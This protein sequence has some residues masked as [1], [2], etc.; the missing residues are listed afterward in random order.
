MRLI[1]TT[2]LELCQFFDSNVPEYAI[3]SHCWSDDEVTFQEFE[4]R[5]NR[6]GCG[7]QKITD[8]CGLA[9]KRNIEWA[10]IDTICIDKTSSTELSEAINSMFRW[11]E[12]AAICFAFLSDTEMRQNGA[13]L[14]ACR[15]F[16]RGWT[17]QELLAPPKV[18][19]LDGSLHHIG[20]RRSLA[21]N[22]AAVTGIEERYLLEPQSFREACIAQRMSWAAG[23][24]TSR[25]EDVAYSL[26]GL[27]NVNMPLLY[28]EGGH[29]AFLR[30]QQHIISQS[31][32]E[33]IFAWTSKIP[34]ERRGMISKWP[35]EFGACGDV[36]CSNSLMKRPPYTLTSQ[37]LEFS[38]AAAFAPDW[39]TPFLPRNFGPPMVQLDCEVRSASAPAKSVSIRL[40]RALDGDQIWHRADASKLDLRPQSRL[41]HTLDV[42][43]HGYTKVYIPQLESE[44]GRY[45][46]LKPERR[47]LSDM[48]I[49]NLVPSILWIICLPMSFFPW[50]VIPESGCGQCSR[51]IV[52]WVYLAWGW[53]LSRNSYWYLVSVVVVL[54]LLG[55]L[56]AYGLLAAAVSRSAFIE[57]AR[58]VLS[59]RQYL[60]PEYRGF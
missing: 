53:K 29:K 43:I 23:R 30:L 14:S 10:W 49:T 2:R 40:R 32:D 34:G 28:G 17:L 33:S 58:F 25:A 36:R 24:Q 4:S 3:L 42:L 18:I 6:V 39:L 48:A 35:S 26:L 8:C 50:Q 7:F 15:W 57:V 16:T 37:G 52:I 60:S 13:E 31:S 55:D 1:H 46:L 21:H 51:D 5:N 12:R 22:I 19:F 9:R 27:F 38:V 54:W 41:W 59:P 44:D 56:K 20:T 45:S 11:Y 47:L